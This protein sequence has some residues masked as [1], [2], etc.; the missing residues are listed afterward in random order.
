MVA[1]LTTSLLAFGYLSL[2]PPLP[3]P[4]QLGKGLPSNF[5]IA[6]DE[7]K[8]R[9]KTRFA[10]PQEERELIAELEKQGFQLDLVNRQ[11]IFEK[12]KFPCTLVWRVYWS[13]DDGAVTDINAK[14]GGVCL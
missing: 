9:V 1:I 10:L 3:R 13:A 2:F 6:D 7:F 12:A 5:A 8:R 4:P 11:A 14:Y